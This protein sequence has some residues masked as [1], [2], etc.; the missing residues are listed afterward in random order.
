[1]DMVQNIEYEESI[2]AVVLKRH[3]QRGKALI[4]FRQ[5]KD[6]GSNGR[7]NNLLNEATAATQLHEELA[8]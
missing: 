4:Y 2:N 3:V 8:V 7:R 1:M 6:I 5:I